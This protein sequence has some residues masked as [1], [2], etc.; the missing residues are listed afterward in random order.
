MEIM[1]GIKSYDFVKYFKHNSYSVMSLLSYASPWTSDNSE[2]T[3]NGTSRKRVPAMG[4]IQSA[5]RKTIKNRPSYES[6]EEQYE[7]AT[8]AEIQ[9]KNIEMRGSESPESINEF[10]D[11]QTDRNTKIN[12]ILN[13]ITSFST[14]D[15]LGDFNPMPY[16]AIVAKTKT[17]SDNVLTGD[18]P[19]GLPQNPLMPKSVNHPFSNTTPKQSSVYYRPSESNGPNYTSYRDAYGK[20]GLTT[21]KEPY[22]SRMG[23]GKSETG[24]KVMDRLNY[25]TQMLESLQME[26][27]NHVTEEFVLY[28]LLGV[29]MIYI[30]DGFSRGGKYVR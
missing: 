6:S 18:L 16:P 17:N 29:F 26:K 21:Q 11:K 10:L 9:H 15:K 22:Y 24:D 5:T 20:E 7:V 2:K 30:V 19:V 27:T 12:S 25:M 3:D 1:R 13:K 8:P 4:G 14:N 28:S 23:I